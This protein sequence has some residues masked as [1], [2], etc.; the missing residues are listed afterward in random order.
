MTAE[1]IGSGAVSAG[2]GGGCLLCV[3]SAARE[4]RREQDESEG[5]ERRAAERHTGSWSGART[6]PYAQRLTFR[7]PTPTSMDSSGAVPWEPRPAVRR[8]EHG[9]DLG[10]RRRPPEE[11][12]LPHLAAQLLE[13][14]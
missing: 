4:G 5:D 1:S 9:V 8:I 11:V 14:A 6:A 13:P 7:A 10:G 12:P 2:G 3:E